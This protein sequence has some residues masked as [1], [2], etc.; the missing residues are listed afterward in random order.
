MHLCPV[1]DSCTARLV[2]VTTHQHFTVV[3]GA[4][5]FIPA[6]DTTAVPV[7]TAGLPVGMSPE[8]ARCTPV[9]VSAL[10]EAFTA[11]IAKLRRQ[12]LSRYVC[13]VR[14]LIRPD[15][16]LLHPGVS[17]LLARVLRLDRER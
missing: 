8:L 10:V 1:Q 11:D 17:S 13:F 3:S 5:A 7:T 15:S 12:R 16:P 14:R 9:L 6:T 4:A 2:G